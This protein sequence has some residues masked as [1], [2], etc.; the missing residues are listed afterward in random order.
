VRFQF[1]TSQ[2]SAEILD[3]YFSIKNETRD[4]KPLTELFHSLQKENFS[5]FLTFLK[6]TTLGFAPNTIKARKMSLFI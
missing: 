1:N 4:L 2:S 5:E 6:L 3:K